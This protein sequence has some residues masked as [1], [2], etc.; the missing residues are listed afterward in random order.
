ML[1]R[2]ACFGVTLAATLVLATGLVA[3]ENGSDRFS[4]ELAGAKDPAIYGAYAQFPKDGA[5]VVP[6]RLNFVVTRYST[7]A[8]RDKI[9]AAA[10]GAAANVADVLRTLPAAGYVNWPGGSS[11]TVRYARR[12]ARP[13]GGHDLILVTDGRVWPWWQSVVYASSPN[14]QFSVIQ[15]RLTADGTGEGKISLGSTIAANKEAGVTLSDYSKEQVVFANVRRE[16]GAR[17]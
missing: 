13:D 12:V 9:F 17:S 14:E 4:F 5:S 1:I 8:E 11:Y 2:K 6:N 16:T 3:Q 10:G 15:V 7:D